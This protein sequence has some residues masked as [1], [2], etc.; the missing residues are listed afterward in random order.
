VKAYDNHRILLL[1]SEQT[2]RNVVI[3]DGQRLL[4]QPERLSVFV[5]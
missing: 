3:T 4:S 5:I 1:D 2:L